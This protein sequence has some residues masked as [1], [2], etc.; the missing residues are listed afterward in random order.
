MP[1][2]AKKGGSPA[3]LDLGS[4]NDTQ[5]SGEPEAL[6]KNFHAGFLL[7]FEIELRFWHVNENVTQTSS[8]R[9]V[10]VCDQPDWVV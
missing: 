1:A 6:S 5:R 3:K 10:I 9:S 8:C 2:K 7:S 4:G